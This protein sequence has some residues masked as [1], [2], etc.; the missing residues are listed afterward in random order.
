MD[1][2]SGPNTDLLDSPQPQELDPSAGQKASEAAG[3]IKNAASTAKDVMGSIKGGAG[4]GLT[5][6]GVGG[7]AGSLKDGL[8]GGG[9]SGA[10]GGAG[11]TALGGAKKSIDGIKNMVGGGKNKS[12]N[13]PSMMKGLE[14]DSKPHD[15][16]NPSSEKNPAA[17]DAQKKM[18]GGDRAKQAVDDAVK[19]AKDVQRGVRAVGGDATAAA[20]LAKE[21]ASHPIQTTK[22]YG[23]VALYAAG[24]FLLQ[25][26]VVVAIFGAI[27]FGV[28]KVALTVKE[29]ISLNPSKVANAL[30]VGT[31]MSKWLIGAA[32]Q[33][34]YE[35]QVDE[36]KRNGGTVLAQ[37]PVT[38]DERNGS[39]V[40]P[41]VKKMYD[42]WDNA[43]L[44]A[45]FLDDYNARVE[46][47][48]AAG[49]SNPSDLSAWN[50]F[51]GNKLIGSM[52]SDK[53]RAFISIFTEDTTHWSDIYTRATLQAAARNSFEVNSFK[54]DL[55]DSEKNINKSRENVT[56]QLVETSLKPVSAKSDTYYRC[57]IKGAADCDQLGL[58]STDSA[59]NNQDAATYGGLFGRVIQAV[60][61]VR[62]NRA[63]EELEKA[64][65]IAGLKQYAQNKSEDITGQ[66][67]GYSSKDA[68][69][70]NI[71]TG[72]SESIL[73]SIESPVEDD[74]IPDPELLLD[75]YDRFQISLENKNYSKV[76]Y[77]KESSQSVAL[78][79]NYYVAGGQ[80]LNNE[81]GLL[82]S[83]AL[84]ENLSVL[85]ESAIFRQ[86]VLG[87]PTGVFAQ[88]SDD[89]STS[90]QAVYNDES[91]VGD[92]SSNPERPIKQASCFSGTLV[93]NVSEFK[94]EKNL[95]QIYGLI[96]A[97]NNE[98]ED[99]GGLFGG[100]AG[101][102]LSDLFAK[103]RQQKSDGVIRTSP[104]A[105]SSLSVD[106]YGPEFDAYTNKVYGVT[107]TGAEINGDAYDTITAAAESLWTSAET[108]DTSSLGGRYQT[109]DEVAQT[110]RYARRFE[111][112]KYA[113]KPVEQRLFSLK[114]SS[115]LAGKLA[116]L[117][118]TNRG[119]ATKKTV[120][121]LTPSNLSSSVASQFTPVALA[122]AATSV[123]P[124]SAIRIGYSANHPSNRMGSS[125]V[126]KTYNCASG[127]PTRE[128][129]SPD[130][131][132]FNVPTSENPCKR[133]SVL[134]QLSTCWFDTE[135]S[136]SFD[137]GASDTTNTSTVGTV[138]DIGESSDGVP[139][140]EGSNEIGDV[141]SRYS[142]S[143][144]VDN[145][146]V[147]KLC[148]V[149][150][151]GGRGNDTSGN[152]IS[153]GIVVNSRVSGAWVALGRAAKADGIELSGSS[154]RLADSCGGTGTGSACAKPGTSMHQLGIAIDFSSMGQ[155]G[156]STSSCSGRKGATSDER[157]NW[158]FS[159]A[160]K[161]G[162]K[163]YSH[164]PWHWDTGPF[165]NR[166][167]SS[168]PAV[169]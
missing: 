115:S 141:E 135:D 36:V 96:E 127:G 45:T 32:T 66:T 54:L 112:L 104:V 109:N 65:N 129:S 62:N 136:C 37:A 3:G 71:R 148:Q 146:L 50:L 118:P 11:G 73:S 154:F 28:Y 144:R 167:D 75:L 23:R 122:D 38:T 83:W 84:T 10:T 91:P 97:K 145:P 113:F 13:A 82:D 85:E 159:N 7:A 142:A 24:F 34:A 42:T 100:L 160:E 102:F 22:R 156:G 169:Y 78:A 4:D 40:S 164:E 120:A 63:N 89:G 44:A 18:S 35:R 8:S 2:N 147:I 105:A 151:V 138:G 19:T 158:L 110:M 76:N 29:G 47:I 131:I 107:K 87:T 163:Q 74:T 20:A 17:A 111:R 6:G 49:K 108:N 162:I 46:P 153:G 43:G 128:V 116:L 86:S 81:M 77:D 117:T 57:L 9:A 93:P 168:S 55:P 134:A 58:G 15:P 130:A 157:W 39:E 95:N 143:L 61:D 25:T 79:L 133:A 52:D 99:R 26:M 98:F 101:G 27:F 166:C 126:Y 152:N 69:D 70:A 139:C 121:L 48:N 124:Q 137:S 68:L 165:P 106:N 149:P 31:D 155:K 56:K 150:D 161:Y 33:L 41:E 103:K 67:S 119:D 1:E 5:G 72:A 114:D 92:V 12:S 132:P 123:N 60:R 30:S 125:E 14:T 16:N 140:A 88:G 94:Q 51:I 59:S 90:C 80:L 64:A 53:A 21:V